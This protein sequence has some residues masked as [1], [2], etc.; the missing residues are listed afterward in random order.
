METL[1]NSAI[2]VIA[3]RNASRYVGECLESI[4]SQDYADLG[5]VLVDDASTDNTLEV[6]S[7]K[8]RGRKDVVVVANKEKCAKILNWKKAIREI[9]VNPESAIF[10][11]DGD[12]RLVTSSAISLMMG[13]HGR[14]D[15]V[16][17]Q[18][19]Y[20]N[21]DYGGCCGRLGQWV[22]RKGEWVSS[23][24]MSFKKHLFDMIGDYYLN[25]VDGKPLP[26]A[27][28][29]AVMFTVMEMAGREKCYF[30]DKVLYL[31]RNGN[32]ASWHSNQETLA[33]QKRC[34]EVVRAKRPYVPEEGLSV[35][36]VSDNHAGVI[37]M[38]LESLYFQ[39]P[40][41][42]EVLIVD[43]GSDGI[44]ELVKGF[45]LGKYP[46]GLRCYRHSDDLGFLVNEIGTRR[47]LLSSAGHIHSPKAIVSHM[48][49][50]ASRLGRGMTRRLESELDEYNP[51]VNLKKLSGNSICGVRTTN[52][53]IGTE[54]FGQAIKGCKDMLSEEFI[55]KLTFL[56]SIPELLDN[57][58][59]YEVKS[60]VPITLP[61]TGPLGHLV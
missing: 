46:F 37:E 34:S 48:S 10:I 42:T 26:A 61:L 33:L 5:I 38:V 41:P 36:L 39:L 50:P 8:L 44:M 21:N 35:I 49:L 53:S 22:I 20:D 13:C 16:W 6:V 56:G 12:D 1:K 24:L 52:F 17:S 28:D 47:V 43:K 7:Q 27:I 14:Y 32:P 15:V 4:L 51:M 40:P 3:E 2:V 11:V 58:V 9:C 59:A 25:D 55:K 18:Y 45:D 60:K 29:Q 54:L 23:H 19:D 30:L 31:Y 57:V